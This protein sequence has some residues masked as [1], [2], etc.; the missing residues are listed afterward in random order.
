MEIRTLHSRLGKY[1]RDCA[2]CGK[3]CGDPSRS[4][5]T[6]PDYLLANFLKAA[7]AAARA[8]GGMAGC[9][10]AHVLTSTT[11]VAH[12]S[13]LA[14]YESLEEPYRSL[15]ISHGPILL[16]SQLG[17]TCTAAYGVSGPSSLR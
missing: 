1:R 10:E 7:S 4:L 13:S 16:Y 5:E 3:S 9:L 15:W 14:S 17:A 12:V 8:G 2:I 11:T 6:P